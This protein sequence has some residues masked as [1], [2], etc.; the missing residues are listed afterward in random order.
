MIILYV[1]FLR[2]N[3]GNLAR[4]VEDWKNNYCNA[5]S[6]PIEIIYFNDDFNLNIFEFGAVIYIC[7]HGSDS[8]ELLMLNHD[9]SLLAHSISMQTVAC[10]FNYDFLSMHNKIEC[11]HIYCCGTQEKNTMMAEQFTKTLLL[12][13]CPVVSYSGALF[14]AN[15]QGLLLT[16]DYG[17]LMPVEKTANRSFT[18]NQQQMKEQTGNC[19]RPDRLKARHKIIQEDRN[20]WWSEA[21]GKLLCQNAS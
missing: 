10:R 3:A 13:S 19:S 11:I 20:K 16:L 14:N 7:A 9:H 6:E 4:L 2:N 18:K 17:Q 1:P 5:K 15:K 12:F 8:D 21:S